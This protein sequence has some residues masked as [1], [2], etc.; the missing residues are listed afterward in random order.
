[1]AKLLGAHQ[2]ELLAR[3]RSSAEVIDHPSA[4]GTTAELDWVGMLS[5]FLPSRYRVSKAFVVDSMGESS[6]EIDIVIHDLHYSPLLF[7][8]GSSRFV[9]A[10][11]V[12]A[13]FEVK[14]V[15][16]RNDLGY[17]ARKAASVRRLMRTSL[18]IRYAG[19]RYPPKTPCPIAAGIVATD[20]A[21]KGPIEEVLREEMTERLAEERLEL[22]CLVSRA[23]F[24]IA[25]KGGQ[26]TRIQTSRP[27]LSA[28]FFLL[29]LLARLQDVGTVPA[30]DFD[31]YLRSAL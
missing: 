17:A 15:L 23:G 6:D 26:V 25:Y 12:Y 2:A 1:M 16:R 21:W 29:R 18:P 31:R 3:L 9:P 5:D 27:G 28:S 4:K 24:E 13:V 8:R 19:G 14:S 20:V 30:M 22:G 11:S 10:E 7:H